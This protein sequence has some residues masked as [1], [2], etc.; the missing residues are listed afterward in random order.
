[1][2]SAI[3]EFKATSRKDQLIS[4][5]ASANLQAR[6][7]RGVGPLN[8]LEVVRFMQCSCSWTVPRPS[9]CWSKG[10]NLGA[11]RMKMV[12]AFADT[13]LSSSPMRLRVNECDSY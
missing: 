2:Y 4:A 7:D 9:L 11:L 10:H 12:V 5:T 3:K 13:V 1:M 8:N 6:T